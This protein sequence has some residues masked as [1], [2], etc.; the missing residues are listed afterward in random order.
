MAFVSKKDLIEKLRPLVEQLSRLQEEIDDLSDRLEDLATEIEE[1]RS[2][3]PRTDRA[4]SEPAIPAGS[5]FSRLQVRREEGGDPDQ[6]G[7][8]L[9]A[10]RS[11]FG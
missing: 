4:G 10:E 11:E 3:R 8:I 9:L 2:T 6:R 7:D 1:K 5:L